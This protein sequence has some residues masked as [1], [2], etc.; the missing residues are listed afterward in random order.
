M[1]NIT[2]LDSDTTRTEE[3]ECAGE[4]IKRIRKLANE[5]S[6][7]LYIDG[8]ISNH[9]IISTTDLLNADE[10]LMTGKIIGG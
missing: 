5:E 7:V 1:I 8:L 3:I 6:K 9:E 4:A 2:I 10:I